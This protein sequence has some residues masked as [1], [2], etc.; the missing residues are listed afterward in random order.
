MSKVI[1]IANEKGGVGK[2]TTSV[3]LGIGL[4][5]H[6]KKVLIADVDPQ[7]SLTTHLG[8]RQPEN[9]ELTTATIMEKIIKNKSLNASEAILNHSE[10]ISI[11]PANIE[12]SSTERA[13]VTTLGGETILKRYIETISHEY[14]YI[15]LDCSPSLGM[16][17]INSLVA[18]DSVIIPVAPK[19]LDAKGLELLLKTIADLDTVIGKKLTIEGILVTMANTQTKYN[20]DIIA[21]I[22]KTYKGKFEIYRK[23]IPQ[24]VRVS[25]ASAVGVSIYTHDPHGKAALAYKSLTTEVLSHG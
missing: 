23:N 11:L 4:A 13:L 3:N 17:T 18:A 20:R 14:D 21:L 12:L 19:Y 25:E 16:L 10:G 24:S 8:F 9:L 5:K 2:T 7:G 6:G 1:A 22:E 15:I